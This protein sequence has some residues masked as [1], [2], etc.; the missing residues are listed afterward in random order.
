MLFGETDGCYSFVN[1]KSLQFIENSD[2]S[3]PSLR[4][5]YIETDAY[6]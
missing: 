1:V 2:L 3:L 5:S 6:T 4:I